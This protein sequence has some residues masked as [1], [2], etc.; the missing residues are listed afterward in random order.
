MLG[1]GRHSTPRSDCAAFPGTGPALGARRPASGGENTSWRGEHLLPLPLPLPSPP[2]PPAGHQNKGPV[3][4]AAPRSSSPAGPVQA[5]GRASIGPELQGAW[6][7]TPPCPAATPPVPALF[8][9]SKRSSW[10][11]RTC[12]QVSGW[13]R[14]PWEGRDGARDLRNRGDGAEACSALLLPLC[15]AL[16]FSSSV[17]GAPPPNFPS[18]RAP[19][20]WA[21]LGS[22]GYSPPPR[23]DG[24][25]WSQHRYLSYF[26]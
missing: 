15:R 21:S 13:S 1:S 6:S 17:M 24:W 2:L 26:G 3:A 20:A 23:G 10:R 18:G 9:Q 25:V 22:A 16:S 7:H 12:R 19:V 8:L 4:A 14:D 5:P 11:S